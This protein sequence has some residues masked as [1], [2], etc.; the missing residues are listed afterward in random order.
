[1]AFRLLARSALLLAALLTLVLGASRADARQPVRYDGHRIVRVSI[2]TDA[3]IK[4]MGEISPDMWSHGAAAGEDADYRVTPEG[5]EA[6]R[7]SGI[8]FVVIN[9]NI[10]AAIDAELAEMQAD[11]AGTY[12]STYRTR[13][14]VSA[15]L[16][17]LIA[18]NP[19]IASRFTLDTQSIEGR[20]IWGIRIR[21][22]GGPSN[23]I[24]FFINGCQHAR[25]WVAVTTT[26]FVADKLVRGYGV[27]PQV[28]S[29]LDNVEFFIVPIVN[30]DGY[31]YSH[32]TERLWRKNRRP[33][34]GGTFGVDNNRNWGYQ[35]G[36]AGASTVPSA[37]DYRGTAA[38]SEPETRAVRD[39]VID[40]ANIRTYIDFHSFSQ[41]IL[42]PWAYTVDAPPDV[43]EFNALGGQMA[44]AI[45]S[46][47]GSIYEPGPVG[48]TLYLASGG[49]VDWFY[50][51]RG[52]YSWT[53]ELRDTGASGFVLP[54]NQIV[55]TGEENW[56]AVK[57]IANWTHT[58]DAIRIT[59][60]PLPDFG[61][62]NTS[63]PLSVAIRALPGAVLNATSP[64]VFYRV[65]NAG[66]FTSAPL[67]NAGAGTF[68]GAL[69]GAA[70]NSTLQHYFSAAANGAAPS[71]FPAGAPAS[72]INLLVAEQTDV[73]AD[74]L[75]TVVPGWTIGAAGDAATSG[76]WLRANPVGSAAQPEDDHTAAPGVNC[77]ITAN[78]T[79]GGA[80]GQADVDGGATTLTSPAFDATGS[81]EA[82]ISFWLWYYNDGAD[83]MPISISN[84]NGSSWTQVELLSAT[85]GAWVR[86]NYRIADFLP[87]T[88]QMKVRW[89]ARDVNPGN[90]VEAGVDDFLAYRVGCDSIPG[91]V[92]G[93]GV[94]NFADL[95]IVL[96][97]FGQTGAGIPGDA[98][99][100]GDVDFADLNIVLSNFGTGT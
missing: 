64:Q 32:T 90:I 85:T 52:I 50:G 45:Q 40:H 28:T 39:F 96:S 98:D 37:E 80:I 89:V 41:L 34:A 66:P 95:N 94:V 63:T 22:T 67:S 59:P 56:A 26:M 2:R 99:G 69:P 78:G 30:P 79:A 31:V 12:F 17:T 74:T 13:D 82:Y 43:A 15:Y 62:P 48:P 10:Q 33:N 46:V 83:T 9:D 58:T 25:E 55:P 75:E 4:R 76:V 35:W 93:D 7:A 70:C 65:G 81:G 84:N 14:E 72:T 47:S 42:S 68:T 86:K 36:G 23:K 97:N 1:M 92:N 6:L 11:G 61:A 16:D 51:S 57:F 20:D 88:N 38:F 24:G 3:D 71:L 100:D 27:D 91:D 29:I 19:A 44:S 53:I 60:G 87:P 8:P 49:S 54:A 5:F 73:L 77:Y 21:G 18:L